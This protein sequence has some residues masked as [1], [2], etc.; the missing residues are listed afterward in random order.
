MTGSNPSKEYEVFG[1]TFW[2]LQDAIVF[3]FKRLISRSYL[4]DGFV[5]IEAS[6]HIPITASFR[7]LAFHA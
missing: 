1:S 4:F 5:L 7:S 2:L 3:T 6:N